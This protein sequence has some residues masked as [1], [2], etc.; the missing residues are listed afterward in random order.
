[1]PQRR[2]EERWDEEDPSMDKYFEKGLVG[3]P[4]PFE[5]ASNARWNRTRGFRELAA[6]PCFAFSKYIASVG[7]SVRD[8]IYEASMANTTASARGTKR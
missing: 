5:P 2:S 6:P 8:K 3:I 4:K 1:M 7:T